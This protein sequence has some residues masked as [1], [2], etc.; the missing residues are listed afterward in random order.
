MNPPP[1][2]D[3][4]TSPQAIGPELRIGPDG[5]RT[6]G[7]CPPGS[8]HRLH[9]EMR[10]PFPRGTSPHAGMNYFSGLRH[11]R[12]Q[13][14][15]SQLF[16]IPISSARFGLSRNLT[17]G[18][19]GVDGHWFASQIPTRRPE[20]LQC[21][22]QGL[23]QL[24]D[25]TPCE[26][27][28]KRSQS[29]RRHNPKRQHPRGGTRPQPISMINMRPAQ[30]HRNHQGQ[31][32]PARAGSPDTTTHP[33]RLIQQ[34]LQTQPLHQGTHCQQPRIRN[35]RFL[36]ESHRQPVDIARYPVHS[37]CLLCLGNSRFRIQLFSQV[38]EAHHRINPHQPP[39]PSVD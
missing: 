18:A 38:R 39:N 31:Y 28:K 13:R 26:R 37:K 4:L 27:T 29:R 11:G 10:M 30:Q 21:L 19:V 23:V 35:Q 34:P 15:V 25:M 8:V 14:V 7:S 20:P 9:D 6:C 22:A 32:L 24:A 36:V 1:H 5:H 12:Y 2:T 3:N 16:G 33:H 17:N